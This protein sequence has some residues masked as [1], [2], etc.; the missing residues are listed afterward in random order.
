MPAYEVLLKQVDALLVASFREIVP[1][2]GGFG[3]PHGKIATYLDQQHVQPGS[4]ILF[5][6]H[7]RSEQCD[8]GLYIDVEA[9]IPYLPLCQATN[10]SPSK[11]CPAD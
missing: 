4:P 5:L 1:L 10:R 2:D 8:D 9:A 3:R 6:L 7:S 11:P